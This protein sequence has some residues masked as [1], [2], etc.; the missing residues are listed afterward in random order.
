M[1]KLCFLIRSLCQVYV[2]SW[3]SDRDNMSKADTWSL[4]VTLYQLFFGALPWRISRL[5]WY[6][7]RNDVRMKIH[8][9]KVDNVVEGAN[10]QWM[11][12]LDVS[13]FAIKDGI[14]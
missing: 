8:E 7:H 3:P 13:S 14:F 11:W 5:N 9:V 6:T 2:G 10:D 1:S 4:G 12:P